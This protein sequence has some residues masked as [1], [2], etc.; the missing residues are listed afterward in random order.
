[1]AAVDAAAKHLI[2]QSRRH[3]ERLYGRGR[4]RGKTTTAGITLDAA[5]VQPV[6]WEKVAR[7]KRFAVKPMNVREAAEEM[8]LLGHT[9]FVF[10]DEEQARVSVLYRRKDGDYG[11]IVPELP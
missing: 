11:V 3:K 5:E 2:D 4:S 8:E 10:H 9:F 1:M 6:A 7:I